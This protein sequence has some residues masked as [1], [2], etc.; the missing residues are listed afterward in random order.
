RARG[1]GAPARLGAHVPRI[2]G[3]GRD[4]T[5]GHPAGA[6]LRGRPDHGPRAGGRPADLSATLPRYTLIVFRSSGYCYAPSLVSKVTPNRPSWQA[7]RAPSPH[8][9]PPVVEVAVLVACW[10]V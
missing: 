10:S 3:D 2:V 4:A 6:D 7:T 9:V 5:A 1:T 8:V